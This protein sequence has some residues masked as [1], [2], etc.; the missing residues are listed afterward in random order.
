MTITKSFKFEYII[1]NPFLTN[2]GNWKWEKV[3]HLNL[4]RDY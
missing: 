4:L 2:C 3:D 1:S